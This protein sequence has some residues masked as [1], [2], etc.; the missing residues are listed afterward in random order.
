MSA[1]NLLILFTDQ[2]RWDTVGA[3]GSPMG[4]TPNL[5]A[6]ARRGT[7]FDHAFTSQPVCAPARAC[8]LT[9]QH[10]TA[11]GVWRNGRS[12]S[13]A[14]TTLATILKTHGYTT[15]YI[16][17]WHLGPDREPPG[18]VPMPYRGGFADLWEAA[19]V[20]EFTSEPYQGNLYDADGREIRFSGTYRVDFLA[21]RVNRFL[22][23]LRREPF[24]LM[25]SWLEPHHQN[26]WNRFVA[27]HGYAEK[28]A[29]PY[30][31]PD[32]RPFPGDW[33]KELP[34]YYGTVAR[35][36]ECIGRILDTLAEQGIAQ[37]TIVVFLSDHG[38]HFRTRNSEYK[39]SAHE[40]CIR[41][42]LIVQGPGFDRSQVVPESVSLVDMA[43]TLL[44]AL[45]LPIPGAMQGRSAMPLVE[46]R[47]GGWSNDVLVQISESM[48]ARALRTERWKYCVVSPEGDGW[49]DSTTTLYTEYQLY[50]L[51]ADPHELVNLAGRREYRNVSAELRERLRALIV[52]A[53]EPEPDIREARL[54]P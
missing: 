40:S 2:Q 12:L 50:D 31:P 15:G 28:Y 54:Y 44:D 26:D 23:T 30:V 3:Y 13:P 25:V 33:Q 39:R 7:R 53:G 38:C 46:R 17:K 6:M 9:G 5:D 32:L 8:L 1:P 24:F 14:A 29:N 34:D 37:N 27:P 43:P 22:R 36:D 41:I 49:R 47:V 19:N 4:L 35:L 21:E 11:H 52:A 45:G 16:G 42:P 20:L 48:V 18:P 10:G 51:F